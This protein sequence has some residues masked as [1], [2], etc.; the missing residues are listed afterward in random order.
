M[1]VSFKSSIDA[2]ITLCIPL[3]LARRR[4]AL[5][6][7]SCLAGRGRAWFQRV[8]APAGAAG[9]HYGSRPR[10]WP[11]WPRMKAHEARSCGL[12][13][14]AACEET[15]AAIALDISFKRTN[16]MSVFINPF[17]LLFQRLARPAPTPE[18]VERDR[19]G[20]RA[21]NAHGPNWHATGR[22]FDF[23]D[24]SLDELRH[25]VVDRS[26]TAL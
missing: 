2:L 15:A 19:S 22:L 13:R 24:S 20:G 18:H 23:E 5:I 6:S 21:A 16:L 4:A 9:G 11:R 17:C 10:R 26:A 3:G 12:P 14:N 7:A 1:S 25:R 8:A